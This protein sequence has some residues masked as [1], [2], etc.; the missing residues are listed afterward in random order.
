MSSR[1]K[2]RKSGYEQRLAHDAQARRRE[3]KLRNRVLFWGLAAVAVLAIVF[4]LAQ[5]DGVS[6]GS[7][8]GLGRKYAFEVGTP[9]PGQPAPALDLPSTQG[10]RFDL[11][12]MHGK[13]V[14]LYFQEGLTCQP[15]WEQLKD[16]EAQKASLRALGIDQV[17]SITTDSLGDLEQKVSD[18]GLAT[19]VLSDEGLTVSKLYR[20]NQYGMMGESRDGHSFVLIGPSGRIRWRADYGGPPNY[21]MYVPVE[22]LLA[23]VREG[24]KQGG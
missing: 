17:A 10:G 9:G 13:N 8:E 7:G 12:S 15:C 18:E 23:D 16:L 22:N 21:T 1:P 2:K 6:E 5:L 3:R 19:P 4:A 11:A 24:I 14:L 20:A